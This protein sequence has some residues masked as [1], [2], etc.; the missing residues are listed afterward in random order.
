[1]D[2]ERGL[3]TILPLLRR[4]WWLICVAVVVA[5]SA[6]YVVT[7]HIKPV[8]EASSQLFV[9]TSSAAALTGAYGD[10]QSELVLASAVADMINSHRVADRVLATTRSRLSAD[11]LLAE[12]NASASSSTPMVTVSV[13]DTS[14]AQA[15]RLAD[16]AASAIITLYQA[17]QGTRYDSLKVTL[18]A[19]IATLTNQLDG[20]TAKLRDLA[21]RSS[22]NAALLSEVASLNAQIVTLQS[23]LTSLNVQL[24]T[25]LLSQAQSD[26][27]LTVVDHAQVPTAQVSPSMRVN[28]ALAVALS[29]IL[30]CGFI[31][32][33]EY[34][35]D[36][37]RSPALLEEQLK[38][39]M[40]A[41][42]SR[43]R[44]KK[45][46]PLLAE[47]P[48]DTNAESFKTLR[49]NVQFVNVDRPPRTILIASGSPS[50]GKTT[51]AA[52]YAVAV[53]QAGRRV[54]LVDCDLRR[55]RQDRVFGLEPTPG[56]TDH[57]ADSDLGL[58]VAR[59]TSVAN[60]RVVTSGP[61]PPNPSELLGS[62]RMAEFL[63]L[64]RGDADLVVLD[65]P[66]ALV[67]TDASVL[68]PQVDGVLLVVDEQTSKMRP[69]L[70]TIQLFNLVG[71]KV[72]G[73]VFNKFDARHGGYGYGYYHYSG[74]Y[75]RGK[76]SDGVREAGQDVQGDTPAGVATG[77]S[78]PHVG[79]EVAAPFA[80][81]SGELEQPGEAAKVSDGIRRR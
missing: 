44:S 1:M 45:Y 23:S 35:D 72:L 7:K 70:R 71:A 47:R 25:I 29:L 50:E 75:R 74:Y 49:T 77:D 78:V 19:Q 32:A 37:V 54:I 59:D 22:A 68:A 57:L 62:H 52:N 5:G 53:A 81:S 69:T 13:K 11:D 3:P 73:V 24:N 10:S 30:T 21:A 41:V 76:G 55:P 38:L 46:T 9:N 33:V 66:P 20:D 64:A 17:D 58:D 79:Y 14:P 36:S 60:L 67:V 31:A 26:T 42:V 61:V 12:L 4:W 39:P 40:L 65:S 63:D 80:R 28:L 34:L 15:A 27:T 51:I 6:S 8:Y 2:L 48:W 56:L 43:F 18:Q 16:A